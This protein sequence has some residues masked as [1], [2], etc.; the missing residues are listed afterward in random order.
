[1]KAAKL[2]GSR[3]PA[4]A[5]VELAGFGRESAGA[6]PNGSL[7]EV[8][9]R[10][11]KAGTCGSDHTSG[12]FPRYAPVV[13]CARAVRGAICLGDSGGAL[14]APGTR[15]VVGIASGGTSCKAGTDAIYAFTGAKAIA[16]FIRTAQR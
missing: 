11:D 10:V 1:V 16:A 2:A 12:A 3:Y 15:T 6:S 8:M 4:G 14:V 13:L 5:S 9:L 7:D